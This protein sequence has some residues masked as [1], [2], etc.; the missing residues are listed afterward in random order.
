MTGKSEGCEAPGGSRHGVGLGQ[1]LH[2]LRGNWVQVS[3]TYAIITSALGCLDMVWCHAHELQR[4]HG[5]ACITVPDLLKCKLFLIQSTLKKPDQAAAV[6]MT[7][8]CV[9]AGREK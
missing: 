9:C 6:P 1:T 2:R 7:C 4:G 3:V 8:L 5:A